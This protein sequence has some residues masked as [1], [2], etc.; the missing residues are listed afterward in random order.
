MFSVRIT[1]T[2]SAAHFLREYKGKCEN[3]HGH[4]WKVE[5]EVFSASLDRSGMVIDFTELKAIVS[6]VLKQ[7]DHCLLNE[8]KVFKKVNPTSENIARFLLDEIAG[9]LKHL[10]RLVKIRVSV[11][12]QERSCATFERKL[13]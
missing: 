9:R 13:R 8:R 6:E 3:L 7:Y 11:W 2:F 5:I 10:R 1:D 12:E 4:N